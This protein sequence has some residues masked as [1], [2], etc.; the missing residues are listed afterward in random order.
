MCHGARLQ[1]SALEALRKSSSVRDF[2]KAIQVED[3]FSLF[4]NGPNIKRSG[5]EDGGAA[6]RAT[7]K[8]NRPPPPRVHEHARGRRAPRLR[9]CRGSRT[10]R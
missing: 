6:T 5:V 8:S 7:R 4:G 10:D 3:R 1:S 2:F 9:R